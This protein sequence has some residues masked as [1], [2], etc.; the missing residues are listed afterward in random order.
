ML[1]GEGV[2]DNSLSEWLPGVLGSLNPKFLLPGAAQ[3]IHP[4]ALPRVR[5]RARFPFP[6]KMTFL[7]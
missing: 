1:P 7:F 6:G 4:F 5:P 3:Q 2:F